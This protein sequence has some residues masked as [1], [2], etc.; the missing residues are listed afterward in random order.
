MA[1]CRFLV[2]RERGQGEPRVTSR[3][4]VTKMRLDGA[5]QALP[6]RALSRWSSS[7]DAL[8]FGVADQALVLGSVD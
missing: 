8:G 7:E 5:Q 2:K 4:S 6:W 3:I 1:V